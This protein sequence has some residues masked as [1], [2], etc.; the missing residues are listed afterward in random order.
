MKFSFI[1]KTSLQVKDRYLKDGEFS[2]WL[3]SILDKKKKIQ[4]VF[5]AFKSPKRSSY[6]D[7]KQLSSIDPTLFFLQTEAAHF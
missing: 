2:K 4:L 5:T 7:R 3:L 6:V 1:R